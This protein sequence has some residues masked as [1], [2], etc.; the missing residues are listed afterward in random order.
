[1]KLED[2]LDYFKLQ[3]LMY[4]A[5]VVGDQP[6]VRPVALIYHNDTCWFVSISGREKIKEIE[7]NNNIEFA[8]NPHDNEALSTI[9][10]RGKA[11]LITN[12][13]TKENVAKVIPWFDAYWKSIDDPRFYLYRLDLGQ[14]SVQ[15][16]AVRDIYTFDLATGEVRIKKE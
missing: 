5:T 10:G 2:V 11:I 3:P 12:L 7:K 1:M 8:V 14:I 15:I 4:L 13:E 16:P 6:R 9:R